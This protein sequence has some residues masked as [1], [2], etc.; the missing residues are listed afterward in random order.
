MSINLLDVKE[1]NVL[2]ADIIK[3]LEKNNHLS[4]LIKQEIVSIL[5][6]KIIIGYSLRR[7]I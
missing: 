2:N 3:L 1:L 6:K 7:L 4:L 5:L